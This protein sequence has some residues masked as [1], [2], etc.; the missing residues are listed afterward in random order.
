MARL[1]F[2]LESD[3][4]LSDVTQ[5]WVLCTHDL[6]TKEER[7]FVNLATDF[8]WKEY[9][10]QATVLSGHNVINYDFNVLKKLYN[11]T[12]NPA[13]AIHDTLIF[14]QMMNFRRFG[15]QGHGLATWG[16]A[17]GDNKIDFEDWTHLSDEMI[18]YCQQ[19]VR[20]NV[21][22]YKYLVNEFTRA[23]YKEPKLKLSMRNEHAAARFMAEAELQGWRF[24]KVKGVELF[25]KMEEELV[26]AQQEI[27][28]FMGLKVDF[29]DQ[30]NPALFLE[31]LPSLDPDKLPKQIARV[32]GHSLA[33]LTTLIKVG[34][35]KYPKWTIKGHYAAHTASWFNVTPESGLYKDC[36]V[37]GPYCRVAFTPRVLTSG[38]DAKVWLKSIGYVADDWNYKRNPETRKMEIVSEKISESALLL[39]GGLG[40]KYNDFLTTSSRA[41]ILRG[42]L[43]MCDE[44]WR[45]HGGA[46]SFG[47][48]TG[49]MTH[50]L[51]ANV[52]SVGN[53]WGQDV[54]SLFMAD[55]GTVIIGCDSSGNQMRAFCHHLDNLDFTTQVISGD[56]HQSNA[57]VLTKVM[58]DLGHNV[59]VTR[60]QAKTF[61]YAFLF[62][63][64]AEK[65][66]LYITGKRDATLG[67]KIKSGFAK[68][69]VGLE[70][71]TKKLENVFSAT[72]RDTGFGYIYALDGSKIYSDSQ[73]KLLNYL[74]QRFESVTVKSAIYHMTKRLNDE[75]VWWRP[76]I[77]MHDEV[78]F[79]VKD[80]PV[81]IE[82]AKGIAH[83]AFKDAA[84]EFGVTITDGEAKHGYDWAET[85]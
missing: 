69:V 43:E 81:T 64:G 53:P 70:E 79:L 50:K 76:L 61:I 54:R 60:K 62:G 58:Q 44:E 37:E 46:M 34:E 13:T 83:W 20:V 68:N 73:H 59:I 33:D 51:V 40:V 26:A 24:N 3:G 45:V 29:V 30:L 72:K 75:K 25:L 9:L 66:A 2:D 74:L 18:T 48:P 42:W 32:A 6:D 15:L 47:T 82:K 80:D 27:E 38:T 1:V 71:L 14:S 78:Q 65:A 57:D 11:W 85:H 56:I 22:V 67:A 84:Q 16:K 10:W 52:P 4:L 49:R 41:N 12:P 28:P 36:I 23:A 35:T 17:L 8:S 31:K 7:T 63:V 55:P 77:I 5:V 21:K 39:L 19:D